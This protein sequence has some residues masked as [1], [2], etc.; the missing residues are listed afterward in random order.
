MNN[1]ISLKDF[2]F[3]VIK[4]MKVTIICFLDGALFLC[5]EKEEQL[6]I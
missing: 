4:I 6:I 3:M 5:F 2:F 1:V